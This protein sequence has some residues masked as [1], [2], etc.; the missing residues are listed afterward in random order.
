MI[1]IAAD[2]PEEWKEIVGLYFSSS[3]DPGRVRTV[4]PPQPIQSVVCEASSAPPPHSCVPCGLV[5]SSPKGYNQHMRA[6]HKVRSCYNRYV[7]D[8]K[9]CPMCH[10]VFHSRVHLVSHLA[11]TRIRSKHRRTT[12]G[13]EFLDSN[14]QEIDPAVLERLNSTDR[15]AKKAALARG[16]TH[17]IATTPAM[18]SKPNKSAV[19]KHRHKFQPFV[20]L[21]RLSTKSVP[22][23]ASGCVE[24]VPVR[25]LGTKTSPHALNKSF[26]KPP[27]SNVCRYRVSSK[28]PDTCR[29]YNAAGRRQLLSYRKRTQAGLTYVASGTVPRRVRARLA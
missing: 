27:I 26:S 11:E 8:W 20:P 29:Y 17:V 16:H 24:V 10:T 1:R 3:D 15:D 5:F 28:Q 2:H 4:I 21:R 14:P 23:R 22:C 25:R 9:A 13:T 12:C 18:Q 6:K 19:D 7:G